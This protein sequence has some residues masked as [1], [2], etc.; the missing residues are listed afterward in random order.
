MFKDLRDFPSNSIL[1]YD[2]C[3]VGTGPAGISVA[4]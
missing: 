3:I 4:K 1:R 2:I